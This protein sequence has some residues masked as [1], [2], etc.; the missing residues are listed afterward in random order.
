MSLSDNFDRANG[1]LGANWTTAAGY[2]GD[3]QISGNTVVTDNQDS[4]R[5]AY[6]NAPGATA[7]QWSE[8]TLGAPTDSANHGYGP[9][10][11]IDG[12]LNTTCYRITGN[13][14]GW[15]L[16]R[17]Y[18]TTSQQWSR[19]GQ[20]ASPTFAAGDR[21][22]ISVV[23]NVIRVYKNDSEFANYTDSN[24]TEG[25]VGIYYSSTDTS[26]ASILEWTGDYYQPSNITPLGP[27]SSGVRLN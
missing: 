25:N 4:D 17:D 15:D 3:L 21:L 11:R 24:L 16:I 22:K 20:G 13:A 8:V 5:C 10:V 27:V 12:A 19:I 6:W 9:A 26:G 7:D 2:G 14:A 18:W 1:G 23:G